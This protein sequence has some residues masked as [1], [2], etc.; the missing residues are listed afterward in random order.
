LVIEL[1]V[2]LRFV[3][4]MELT[5][6]PRLKVNSKSLSSAITAHWANDSLMSLSHPVIWF[7]MVVA[8][9]DILNIYYKLSE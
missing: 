4:V 3:V 6:A 2:S 5:K 7:W 8:D 9:F 1:D